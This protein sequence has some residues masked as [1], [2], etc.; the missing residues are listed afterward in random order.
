MGKLRLK[1]F[2]NIGPCLWSRACTAGMSKIEFLT[3]L[4]KLKWTEWDFKMIPLPF[5]LIQ[6]Y[7]KNP[8]CEKM[9]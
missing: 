8:V 9:L 4:L 5:N 6:F 3:Y 7:L 2:Y 1:K